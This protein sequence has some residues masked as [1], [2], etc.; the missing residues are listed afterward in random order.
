MI[1]HIA[2]NYS[3]ATARVVHECRICDKDFHSF[4]LLRENKL[5]GHG[6]QRSSGA[7]KVDVT[8]LMGDVDDNSLKE[9][10]ES[11]KHLLVDSEMEI[12]RHIF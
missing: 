1:Y 2:K 6:A 9:E 7:Q 11:C 10:L 3:K 5:K 4:F 12:G 8:Q